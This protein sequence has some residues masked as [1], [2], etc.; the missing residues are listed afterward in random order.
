MIFEQES[1]CMW[2]DKIAR[3]ES[4]KHSLEFKRYAKI[5][6]VNAF[7]YKT[8]AKT[9]KAGTKQTSYRNSVY[10]CLLNR[11]YDEVGTAIDFKIDSQS[12][13]GVDI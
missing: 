7:E 9:T 11:N 5:A 3:G 2:F 1:K 10:N 4:V 8:S 6:K 13:V 12:S